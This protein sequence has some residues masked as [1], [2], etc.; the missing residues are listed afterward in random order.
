MPVIR[1]KPKIEPLPPERR[2]EL[3][4]QL[5]KEVS[6]ESKSENLL[7]FEIPIGDGRR[8]DVLVVWSAWEQV[9]SEDRTDLILE[10]Y[11]N[12]KETV[13]QALGVTFEEAMDQSLLPY[14]VLPLVRT[15]EADPDDLRRLML[16]EGAYPLGNGKIVLR[17]PTMAMA[18]AAHKRLCEREPKGHWSIV[19]SLE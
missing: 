13:A 4:R 1:G 10:V 12:Q 18:E 5:S 3:L 19:Q 17:F 8:F 2:V 11:A 15:R 7:V 9:R 14:A 16:E 6:G